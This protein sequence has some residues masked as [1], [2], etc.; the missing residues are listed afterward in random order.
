MGV[1]HA[2][3]TEEGGAHGE[4]GPVDVPVDAGISPSESHS[5]KWTQTSPSPATP[6]GQS[7]L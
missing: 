3:G 1:R 4:Q 5:Q 2:R 6:F 7:G